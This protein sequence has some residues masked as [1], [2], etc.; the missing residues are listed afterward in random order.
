MSLQLMLH[1]EVPS[2]CNAQMEFMKQAEMEV[3]S[4]ESVLPAL[5]LAVTLVDEEVNKELLP[6]VK[7][8]QRVL[9]STCPVMGDIEDG[10]LEQYEVALTEVAD[11]I[12]DSVYVLFQL[13]NTL[14]L[15]FDELFLAVH[16]NNM[17]KIQ[18]DA[19]GK[20]RKREDG[21]LL[22][23]EGYKKVDLRSILFPAV[24]IDSY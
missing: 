1:L 23:P 22:K 3:G 17:S 7:E 18:H 8:L 24:V 5:A 2:Q 14:Q 20:L 19:D 13:A 11:G 21:K 4:T 12:V 6:A 10:Y 16:N 15:P 9:C